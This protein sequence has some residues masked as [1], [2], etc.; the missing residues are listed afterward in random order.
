MEDTKVGVN[1]LWNKRPLQAFVSGGQWTGRRT[2]VMGSRGWSRPKET[3]HKAISAPVLLR[4]TAA[5]VTSSAWQ[6][7]Q[8]S[9]PV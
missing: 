9:L 2:G 8:G 7:Y 4:D 3:G 1:Q 6:S 5:W